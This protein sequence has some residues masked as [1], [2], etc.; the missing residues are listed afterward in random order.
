MQNAR[1]VKT[2]VAT[3][4]N[5]VAAKVRIVLVED[6][7]ILKE[8]LVALLE[9]ETDLEIVGEARDTATAVEL[10]R[11]LRPDILMTDLSLPGGSGIGLI[12]AVREVAPETRALVLTAHHEEEYFRAA[13]DAGA[14][15]YV[16]KDAGRVE[17]L[18]AIRSVA[19]G[20]RFLS[21]ALA[22]KVLSGYLNVSG[23]AMPATPAQQLTGREREVLAKIAGG[24]SNKAIAGLLAIS[25]KTVEKHRANLM[26]KLGLRNSAEVTMFAIRHGLINAGGVDS[27]P[28]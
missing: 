27:G 4:A 19:A 17:L 3:A 10:V 24:Q 23:Q 5:P 20:G 7:A 11:S 14:L 1:A 12:S 2:R 25:V 18:L 22:Q 13:M 8:G 6:H 28:W 26:R 15:G 16:L 9:I 21:S